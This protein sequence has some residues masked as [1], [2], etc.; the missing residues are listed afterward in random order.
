MTTLRNIW[1][2]IVCFIPGHDYEWPDGL[3]PCWRCGKTDWRV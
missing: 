2:E 3:G 1:Q